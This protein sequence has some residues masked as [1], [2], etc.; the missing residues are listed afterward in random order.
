MKKRIFGI[1]FS[2]L[3]IFVSFILLVLSINYSKETLLLS[4]NVTNNINYKVYLIDNDFY[5]NE[6]LTNEKNYP[7]NFI[8]HISVDFSSNISFNKKVDI[9][10]SYS[11]IARIEVTD[12]NK[13]T[14]NIIFTK[15]YALLSDQEILASDALT[16]NIS[17]IVDIDYKK[18]NDV[19]NKYKLELKMP[20]D[21]KLKIIMKINNKNDLVDNS[22]E[23]ILEMPLSVN[24]INIIKNYK[25]NYSDNVYNKVNSSYIYIILSSILLLLSTIILVNIFKNKFFDNEN[26]KIYKLNKILKYYEQIIVVVSNFPKVDK[27]SVLRVNEF[28][29]MVDLN[30]ELKQPI[31]Y[32]KSDNYKYGIFMLTSLDKTYIYE[33]TSIKEKT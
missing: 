30:R 31:L 9:N 33:I 21:S 23:L 18:Y 11:I 26:Y 4:Y 13:S 8:D 27:A 5:D 25:E 22:D 14:N 28:K 3:G 7:V 32:Y 17:K 24:T 15:D 19:V 10:Y 29:D 2:I 20:V 6:Y 16:N 12:S 1:I